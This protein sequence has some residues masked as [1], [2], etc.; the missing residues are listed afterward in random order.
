MSLWPFQ[1][2]KHPENDHAPSE[3]HDLED[4]KPHANEEEG[5]DEDLPKSEIKE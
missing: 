3:Y 5:F 2:N 4:I 1:N